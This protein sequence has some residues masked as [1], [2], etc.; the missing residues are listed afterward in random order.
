MKVITRA[1]AVL[2]LASLGNAQDTVNGPKGVLGRLSSSGVNSSVD[3]T[4]SGS[5]APVKT[6]TLAGRPT[7]CTLGQIYFATDVSAGQNLYVCTATGAPGTWTLHGGGA[8]Y[9][10]SLIFGPDSTRTI[11]GATHGFTTTALLVA[12]YDNASPRNAIQVAWTV[13]ASTYDVTIAFATPQ[14]NYY[15]VINGGVG[16][17]G[18]PGPSGSSGACTLASALGFLLNGTDE[19]TLLNSVFAAFYTAGGGCLAID[20]N[21]T[22]RA[23]GQITLPAAAAGSIQGALAG[24]QPPYRITGYAGAAAGQPGLVVGGSVLDL[25]YHGSGLTAFQGGPK[26]LSVGQGMLEIDHI[27]IKTGAASDCATFLMT[28]GTTPYFH[29][30]AIYGTGCNGGIVI[31]GTQAVGTY[32]A[33]SPLST[34]VTGWFNGYGGSIENV[35]LFGIGNATAPGILLQSQVNQFLIRHIYAQW[36]GSS[37]AWLLSGGQSYSSAPGSAISIVGHGWGT[38]ADRSNVIDEGIIEVGGSHGFA[39]DYSCAISLVHAEETTIT[40]IGAYDGD[41]ST[42]LLCGDSTAIKNRVTKTNYV[43]ST[44][45]VY[46]NGTWDPANDM[47]YRAIPFTFDGGGAVPAAATA[48]S[49]ELTFGGIIN[50]FSMYGNAS[51]NATIV[52]SAGSSPASQTT[53]S[54]TETMSSAAS[55]V[56]TTL[57]G[58]TYAGINANWLPPGS[59]VCVTLSSPATLHRL[60]GSLR[61]L[62]GR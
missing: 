1:L 62:E 34:A 37:T 60:A 44:G 21:K 26:L 36:G 41:S 2:A 18:P 12:V 28:T 48:C 32:A 35:K 59:V 8:P 17:A 25:R 20:P 39:A 43:D 54:S 42:A 58:W 57:A 24:P 4:A 61:V 56:D 3:F 10:S 40:N 30:M 16:P 29:D 50:R 14:S 19:T 49:P 23:D 52:V 55:L 46:T 27:T 9:I 31:A 45:V 53:I 38:D 5:T 51:G 6:G 33:N 11:A 15:V 13:N 22:L 47:P 7:G